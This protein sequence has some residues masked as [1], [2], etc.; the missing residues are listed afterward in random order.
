MPDSCIVC[1]GDLGE[2]V[3]LLA[4]TPATTTTT[5]TDTATTSNNPSPPSLGDDDAASTLSTVTTATATPNIKFE[6]D[7]DSAAANLAEITDSIGK[8][9]RLLPCGHVLHDECLKPWVERANSCPICRQTFN[10]VNVSDKLGGMSSFYSCDCHLYQILIFPLPGPVISSY[11]VEDRIQVAEVDPFMVIEEEEDAEP[12][13]CPNCGDNDHE[14]VLLLCDGC[15]VPWHTYCVGLDGVPTGTWYCETCQSQGLTEYTA[16]AAAPTQTGRQSERTARTRG[17]QRATRARNQ[18]HD[19]NWSRVWMSVFDRLNIDLDF[20][21]DGGLDSLDSINARRYVDRRPPRGLERRLMVAQRQG[22][23]NRFREGLEAPAAP[24]TISARRPRVSIP[25]PEPESMDEVLAWNAFERARDAQDDN[26]SRNRRKRKSPTASP[27][28]PEQTTERR[29][30]KRP[31]TRRPQDLVSH[32]AGNEQHGESSGS[33]ARSGPRSSL[34]SSSSAAFRTAANH[35]PSSSLAGPSF[36]QSLLKEVEDSSTSTGNVIYRPSPYATVPAAGS[37]HGSPGPSSPRPSSPVLSAASPS[38]ASSPR[39]LS[40]SPPPMA[41][42]PL[43][44]KIEPIFMKAEFS[45]N[46][47]TSL[48][49]SDETATPTATSPTTTTFPQQQQQQPQRIPAATRGRTLTR[50]APSASSAP[51]STKPSTTRIPD[52]SPARDTLTADAKADVSRMVSSALKP[53][54][55]RKAVTKEQYININKKISRM[56]Y[57]VV[58][59]GG[60]EGGDERDRQ[61]WERVASDEV[62]KAVERLRG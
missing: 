50:T 33:A 53:H 10:Q 17:R 48:S 4:A 9:A 27:A 38:N 1:L 54:Y 34:S 12:L 36:L 14:E 37:D 57:E 43:A 56:M 7:D 16:A 61:R 58:G 59:E 51:T 30:L 6:L 60:L 3:S 39:A 24:A 44:S 21:F 42:T 49:L 25:T 29:P 52:H 26:G 15:D 8:I 41:M 28:E 55:T 20:P 19:S 11:A 35:A 47:D 46:R 31:R 23:G 13:V 32:L 45:P 40:A 18:V 62:A 5:A 2:D 22:A